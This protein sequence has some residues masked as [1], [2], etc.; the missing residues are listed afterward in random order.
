M[1]KLLFCSLVVLTTLLFFAEAQQQPP[2]PGQPQGGPTLGRPVAFQKGIKTSADA[3][4]FGGGG[5]GRGHGP[6]G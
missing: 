5:G 2:P 1:N 3:V 6:H 4:G